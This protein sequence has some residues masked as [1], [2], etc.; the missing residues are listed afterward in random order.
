MTDQMDFSELKP[1]IR[2]RI[3]A[4]ADI[5]FY[6]Q[7]KDSPDGNFK[8]AWGEASDYSD[9]GLY[10]LL[11]N[12]VVAAMVPGKYPLEAVVANNGIFVVHDRTNKQALAHTVITYNHSGQELFR[13]AFRRLP[14]AS[15][16]SPDGKFFAVQTANGLKGGAIFVLFDVEQGREIYRVKD[17]W[18]K[19]VVF[20]GNCV[21]IDGKTITMDKLK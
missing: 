16:I 8:I 21:Q 2:P 18:C 3:V 4:I 14:A 12:G 17:T 7:A 5:G 9:K 6:G 15:W 11:K 19:D 10:V 20:S 1:L 13:Q